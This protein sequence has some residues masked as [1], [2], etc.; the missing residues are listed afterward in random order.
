MYLATLNG[1]D[2]LTGSEKIEIRAM[3]NVPQT[4]RPAPRAMFWMELI[5]HANEKKYLRFRIE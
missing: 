5:K 4:G 1:C 3:K 2:D